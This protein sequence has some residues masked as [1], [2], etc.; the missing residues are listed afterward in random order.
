MKSTGRNAVSNVVRKATKLKSVIQSLTACYAVA[1]KMRNFA[2]IVLEAT[3]A[4]SRR[5]I[6]RSSKNVDESSSSEPQPL[7]SSTGSAYA[8]CA[9]KK[10][11][12]S[13]GSLRNLDQQSFGGGRARPLFELALISFPGGHEE[14]RR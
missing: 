8:D 11:G 6:R 4:P 14:A 12:C 5:P 2:S 10:G 9:R 1:G 7:R 13:G 3:D